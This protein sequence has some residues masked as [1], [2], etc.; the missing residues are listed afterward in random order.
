MGGRCE[1]FA[2][3][4]SK[5]GLLVGLV[6]DDGARGQTAP[7]GER[8][9]RISRG[10]QHL[11]IWSNLAGALGKLQAADAARHYDV[12]EQ[13]VSGDAVTELLQSLPSVG[14]LD[15]PVAEPGE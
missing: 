4:P 5:V 8:L 2:Q 10:Q 14:R 13:N 6:D 3:M 11:E 12:G 9:Q 7:L 15:H 1:R